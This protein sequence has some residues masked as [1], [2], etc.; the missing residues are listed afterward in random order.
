MSDLH[1]AVQ[2][3]IAARTPTLPPSFDGLLA[4][5]RSRDRRTL[6]GGGFLIAAMALAVAVALP[7][8]PGDASPERVA[9]LATGEGPAEFDFALRA[10]GPIEESQAQG[11]VVQ[12]CLRLPG[13]SLNATL[14]SLPPQY[15]GY[16]TGQAERMA[17]ELCLNAASS[18]Q[19]DITPSTAYDS[20]DGPFSARAEDGTSL[21]LSQDREE[22][23]SV[24]VGTR[25]LVSG[26]GFCS[27][28][29][30]LAATPS[31]GVALED[32][33]NLQ[34]NQSGGYVVSVSQAPC[35]GSP[36]AAE[37]RGPQRLIGSFVLQVVPD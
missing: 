19:A 25:V 2:A 37:C 22:T 32:G 12:A 3:E 21:V 4:R 13:V 5:K 30:S 34:A 14:Y 29:L 7:N 26:R 9:P 10:I 18:W 17:F 23:L 6:V 11:E 31:A 16:V 27:E 24:A 20:C 28:G 15:E 36:E 8:L 1:D 33:G 35:A